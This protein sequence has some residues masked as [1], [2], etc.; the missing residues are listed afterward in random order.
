M[1]ERINLEHFLSFFPEIDLPIILSEEYVDDFSRNNTPLNPSAI[2]D[3]I[4]TWEGG[5]DDITEYVPCF[6]IK[7]TADIHAIIYWKAGL[8]TYEYVL[9]TLDL[10]GEM[11]ERKV[12]ASTLVDGD[13]IKKSVATIDPDWIIH[14]VAG[15]NKAESIEYNADQ[16]QAFNMELLSDGQIIFNLEEHKY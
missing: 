13:I 4:A 3:W 7:E 9:V 5:L 14:I 10:T 12:I 8:M 1:Q 15:A 16:S 2:Y 11:I 6:K